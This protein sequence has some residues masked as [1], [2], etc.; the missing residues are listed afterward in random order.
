MYAQKVFY[1]A[2]LAYMNVATQNKLILVG[3][4]K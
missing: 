3:V 1:N 2:Y 4:A